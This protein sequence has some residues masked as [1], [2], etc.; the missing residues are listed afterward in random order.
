MDRSRTGAQGPCGN[1]RQDIMSDILSRL[2]DTIEARKRSAAKES[3]VAS[4]FQKGEDAILKKIGEEATETVVAAKNGVPGRIVAEIA[5][6]WFHSLILLASHD[7]RPESVL[8]ELERREG[9]SG[10][11]EKAA[12]ADSP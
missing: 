4:L 9:V 8:A 5:D 12:R 3:Y 6:L 2:A 7:L 11:I 1:L 10:L